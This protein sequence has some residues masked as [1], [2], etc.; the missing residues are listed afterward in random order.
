MVLIIDD[1][2]QIREAVKEILELIDVKSIVAANG[3][4]GLELFHQHRNEI[5]CIL[6]DL[7]MPGL[8]GQEIFRRIREIDPNMDVILSTGYDNIEIDKVLQADS[9]V[10]FL[11][12]PYTVDTLLTRIQSILQQ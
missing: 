8:S 3:I 11:H 6:L 9:H 1:E 7:R 2:A 4:D 12:K 10:Y 5:Q